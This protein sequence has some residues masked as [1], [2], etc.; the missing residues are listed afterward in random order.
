MQNEPLTVFPG[1]HLVGILRVNGMMEE[2]TGKT[3]ASPA[4]LGNLCVMT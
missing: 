3:T 1:V 4:N 2:V